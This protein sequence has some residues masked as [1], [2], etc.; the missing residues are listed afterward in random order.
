MFELSIKGGASLGKVDDADLQ[1]LID[2]LEE[3]HASDTDYFISPDTI[4]FLMDNGASP[5]LLKILMEA[6]GASDGVDI[7]WKKI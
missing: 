7:S 3:E 4:E 1:V 5:T 2:Q 6:I